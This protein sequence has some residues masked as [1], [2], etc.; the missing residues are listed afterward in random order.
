[1]PRGDRTGP[2]GEGRGTGR[3]MGYCA[4]YEAPGYANRPG[5]G[6]GTAYGPGRFGL[7][8]G[9]AGGGGRG[10]RHRFYATGVPFSAYVSPES[11]PQ[12]ERNEEIT[13]L[14]NE[15]DYLRGKLVDIE[16]RLGELETT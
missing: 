14:R 9:G 12:L 2:L 15:A 6:R 4:G 10:H 16:R 7:G 8:P 11:A 1:M 5:L 13:L 3:R